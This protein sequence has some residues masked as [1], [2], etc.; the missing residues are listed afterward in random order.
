MD[1]MVAG[2]NARYSSGI[3][4]FNGTT[5]V[6]TFQ[7]YNS[8]ANAATLTANGTTPTMG[9]AAPT[10]G[11]ASA[12]DMTTAISIVSVSATGF[13]IRVVYTAG[14]GGTSSGHCNFIAV[15]TA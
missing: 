1:G 11:D 14:S 9:N 6:G 10:V 4:F 13:T 8:Q 12:S 3:G 5:A 2:G 15:A 7:L